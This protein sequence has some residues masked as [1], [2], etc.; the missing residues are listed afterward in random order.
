MSLQTVR[1][2]ANHVESLI[3]LWHIIVFDNS[4]VQAFNFLLIS[5]I[6]LL[7]DKTEMMHLDRVPFVLLPMALGTLIFG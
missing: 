5:K 7:R 6:T 1:Q 2:V 4:S 3:S